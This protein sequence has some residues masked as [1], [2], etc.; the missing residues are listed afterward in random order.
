MRQS[1]LRLL[2]DM[3]RHLPAS[4]ALSDLAP[5]AAPLSD[6]DGGAG[7]GLSYFDIACDV[8]A[9]QRQV[10]VRVQVTRV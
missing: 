5:L 8:R 10:C 7:E 1:F 4:F 2:R 9:L 6:A 3:V